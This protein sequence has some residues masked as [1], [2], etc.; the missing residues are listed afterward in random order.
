MLKCKSV[1]GIAIA[2]IVALPSAILVPTDGWAQIEEIVV[3]TRRR[4][5]N[6]QE[7]PSSVTAISAQMIERHGELF[8]NRV[9]TD[10]EIGYCSARK[11]ATQHARLS[12]RS[13]PHWS[14]P[15]CAA[16]A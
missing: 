12:M 4:E 10:H 13:M 14:M 9:Y 6:L 16:I 1:S 8:I 3:T 11:S 7:V 5:E 15:R 2:I